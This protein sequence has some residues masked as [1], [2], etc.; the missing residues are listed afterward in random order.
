M[1]ELKWNSMELVSSH[2]YSPMTDVSKTGQ[3]S[4]RNGCTELVHCR[5][6]PSVAFLASR[7]TIRIQFLAT[8]RSRNQTVSLMENALS[9]RA[10]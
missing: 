8:S 5:A 3:A 6:K 9:H 2:S 10:S 4:P 7:E 1:Y